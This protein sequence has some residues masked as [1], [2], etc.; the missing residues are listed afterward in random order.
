MHDSDGFGVDTGA[1]AR[2]ATQ[3]EPLAGRLGAI[4]R[5]LSEALTADGAPWGTDAV[6]QSF[7][8]VHADPADDVVRRLSSL[9]ERLGSVGT[10][11]SASAETYGGVDAAALERMKAAEQ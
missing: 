5:D 8:S 6:G 1:L 3:F 9:P 4:H 2:R 11:L 10:R 7:S